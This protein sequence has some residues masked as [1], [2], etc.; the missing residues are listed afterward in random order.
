MPIVW[1]GFV[2]VPKKVFPN[3]S[4]NIYWREWCLVW[5]WKEYRMVSR[6]TRLSDSKVTDKSYTLKH[7]WFWGYTEHTISDSLAEDDEYLVEVGYRI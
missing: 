2:V 6:I 5:P 7:W 3:V 1:L 4:F